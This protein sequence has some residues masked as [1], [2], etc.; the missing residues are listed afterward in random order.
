MDYDSTVNDQWDWLRPPQPPKQDSVYSSKAPAP[1]PIPG[2]A[3]EPRNAKV[4]LTETERTSP[5]SEAVV[6]E[7]ALRLAATQYDPNFIS[8]EQLGEMLNLLKNGQVITAHEEDLL[9]S[10]PVRRRFPEPPPGYPRDLLGDWQARHDSDM[11]R[12]DLN[13][14]T[15]SAE[16]ISLL[17][18]IRLTREMM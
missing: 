18:R 5:E 2:A 15:Q 1:P 10:D 11:A 13:R 12:G 6:R 7:A 16:A 8:V 4:M 3:P 9:S 14:L 17:T